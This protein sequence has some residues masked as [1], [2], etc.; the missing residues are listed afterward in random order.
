MNGRKATQVQRSATDPA[1]TVGLRSVQPYMQR[2]GSLELAEAADA[3]S[4]VRLGPLE[5]RVRARR[6]DADTGRRDPAPKAPQPPEP[7]GSEAAESLI[8]ERLLA[9]GHDAPPL[10]EPGVSRPASLGHG[11]L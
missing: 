11:A 9:L 7:M 2:R 8:A 6:R 5:G 10:P 3:R 1:I 4:Q